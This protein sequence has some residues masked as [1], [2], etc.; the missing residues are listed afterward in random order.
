MYE[1]AQLDVQ[2]N[3]GAT[4]FFQTG[5]QVSVFI[6]YVIYALEVKKCLLAKVSGFC[7]S[8][9]VKLESKRKGAGRRQSLPP[10][11]KNDH[12]HDS[13]GGTTHPEAVSKKKD[14]KSFSFCICPILVPQSIVVF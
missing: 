13:S 11:I 3:S 12:W 14:K 1:W 6:G 9:N 5:D 8:R 4:F 2:G 7:I 10:I